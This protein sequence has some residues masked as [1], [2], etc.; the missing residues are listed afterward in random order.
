MITKI[1][2][3]LTVLMTLFASGATFAANEIGPGIDKLS[4]L[5]PPITDKSISYLSQLFGTVGT[6]LHGTSGELLAKAF[7]IFNLGVLVIASV[8][9]TY[10][11]FKSVLGTAQDG[12]FMGKQGK[13]M[14]VAIRTC[15]GVGFL[16][17]VFGGYSAIQVLMMW[18]VVHGVGFA[19]AAWARTLTYMRQGGQVYTAPQ[20]EETKKMLDKSAY[21]LKAQICSY[22]SKRMADKINQDIQDAKQKGI[23]PLGQPSQETG[24]Y[25][26]AFDEKVSN[27]FNFPGGVRGKY[28][29]DKCGSITFQQGVVYDW[30]TEWNE[31]KKNSDDPACSKIGRFEPFTKAYD[32][33]PPSPDCSPTQFTYT[34]SAGSQKDCQE[35]LTGVK[36]KAAREG[37]VIDEAKNKQIDAIYQACLDRVGSNEGGAKEGVTQMGLDLGPIAQDLVSTEKV[38]LP[39]KS[40]AGKPSY[41][42]L[43]DKVVAGLIGAAADFINITMP[44]RAKAVG[45]NN[46]KTIDNYY[47]QAIA[48]G[49]ITAGALYYDLGK[50]QREMDDSNANFLS[51]GAEPP[52]TKE[53]LQKD[54]GFTSE[55][56]IAHAASL[57]QNIGTKQSDPDTYIKAAQDAAEAMNQSN[58][59]DMPSFAVPKE[60][61]FILGPF[62]T[63]SQ[64]WRNAFSNSAGGNPILVLQNL[65][66]TCMDTAV[67]VYTAAITAGALLG[68][69]GTMIFGSGSPSVAVD[70][71]L[72]IIP[73]VVFF[74]TTLFATGS[75]LAIYVP[76]I[77]YLL[78]I[79]G[80]IGWI[81]TVLE[82]MVAAP[83]VAL[84]VTHPE[85]HDLLGKS[86]QAIMLML[87]V[88]LRPVLM[89]IGMLGGMI[90][91]YVG[92]RMI[93]V[94]FMALS[95]GIMAGSSGLTVIFILL[96][97]QII[98]VSIVIS[99]IN[100]AYSLIYHVPDKVLRWI[101]APDQSLGKPEGAGKVEHAAME[102]GKDTGAKLGEAQ[103][104]AQ[105][106]GSIGKGIVRD[107]E[108]RE[109][110]KKGG[111]PS[112]KTN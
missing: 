3:Y 78:F 87:G 25:T 72:T 109:D 16:A 10:T 59:M 55:E 14:W 90:L 32:F 68:L 50:I 17:P 105:D 48:N 63:L 9:A 46:Q 98:Y 95:N 67:A 23:Q 112:G 35:A 97:F 70:I 103:K 60:L 75:M 24:S 77:P 4:F 2:Y 34:K 81:I 71:M 65:G 7:E 79:F 104:G 101:G 51:P 66:Y 43:T 29:A 37:W 111:T 74:F 108:S 99:V 44:Q 82:A 26:P 40:E 18:V 5:N 110:R 86:E 27:K 20:D 47:A 39:P 30:V 64:A 1:R 6:V 106:I 56:I 58:K 92:L 33:S 12:E 15:L 83:L 28:A 13:S 45:K 80:A 21:V 38:S 107:K 49:W 85:G 88:F 73:I 19:D 102:A 41:A 84:G 11:V 76:I 31:A 53:R 96:I 22:E 62:T 93:N 54:L 8:F 42:A 52:S 91:S 57:M 89:V 61:A 36:D 100:Q 69:T 94:G